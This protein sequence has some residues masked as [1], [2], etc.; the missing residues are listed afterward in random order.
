MHGTAAARGS[1]NQFF[2]L[3]GGIEQTADYSVSPVKSNRVPRWMRS[4]AKNLLVSR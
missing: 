4:L 1:F 3:S 2:K